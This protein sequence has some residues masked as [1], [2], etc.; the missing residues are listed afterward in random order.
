MEYVSVQ[1][2]DVP[3]L[4]LGTWRLTG[5]DCFRAVSNALE[6]GYR[7]L[8]TARNYGNEQSVGEAIAASDVPRD[9]VFLVTKI[10]GRA[11]AYDDAM[12]AARESVRRLGVDQVDLLLLH[13]PNPLVSVEESMRAL[14]ACRER[15]L[16]RHVG[17]SNF[18][19]RRLREA[20]RISPVPLLADQVQFHPYRPQ[21]DLLELCRKRDVLLT[22]YSPLGHGGV[23]V[24]DTLRKVGQRY[25]KTPAQVALRWAIQH[26]N[27]AAIPKAS[28]RRHLAENVEIFD[29]ALTRYEMEQ[30]EQASLLKTGVSWMR[31]RLGV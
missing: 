16:T 19:V 17:V 23:V 7:H 30:V 22:A 6:L 29:F 4:G 31:G 26:D 5:R 21:R 20:M 1:G 24:D 12:I 27:V 28:S 18:S 25:G 13:S 11:A 14:A 3:A 9:D 2:E 8:D 10:P 15:G